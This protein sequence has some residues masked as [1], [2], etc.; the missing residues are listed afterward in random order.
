M[1]RLRNASWENDAAG[2]RKPSLSSPP[3]DSV[4]LILSSW[5]AAGADLC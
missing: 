3:D 1:P 5:E 2:R 4:G